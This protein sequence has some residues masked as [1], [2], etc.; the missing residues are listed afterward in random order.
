MRPCSLPHLVIECDEPRCPSWSVASIAR[1]RS[2]SLPGGRPLVDHV[3][4]ALPSFPHCTVVEDCAG[5][6]CIADRPDRQSSRANGP[7][8]H[9]DSSDESMQCA[10]VGGSAGDGL[11]S[12][13]TAYHID[14]AWCSCSQDERF[15]GS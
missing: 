5:R 1:V 8:W 2:R 10:W 3:A 7:A 9:D 13:L 14:T 4:M 11:A 12:R 6:V 15:G